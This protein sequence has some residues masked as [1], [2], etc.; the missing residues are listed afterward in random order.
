MLNEI[1]EAEENLHGNSKQYPEYS[2]MV[3]RLA[4][5]GLVEKEMAAFFEVTIGTLREWGRL[6]RFGFGSAMRQGRALSDAN[7]VQSLYRRAT[8]YEHPELDIRVVDGDIVETELTKYYPPDTIA[9]IF[10]LKN[11]RPDLWRDRKEFEHKGTVTL[12][13]LITSS[14][15]D[16]DPKQIEDGANDAIEGESEEVFDDQA[17]EA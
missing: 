14:M 2:E 5:L 6:N 10:W 16:G 9:C 3:L 1:V 4:R 13:A 17:E 8:G 15:N 7:V 11:R 12:E